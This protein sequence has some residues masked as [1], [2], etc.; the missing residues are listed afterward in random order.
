MLNGDHGYR[1]WKNL[2][3]FGFVREYPDLYAGANLLGFAGDSR[4]IC[5]ATRRPDFSNVA[6]ELG[7]PK[8]MEF[9]Q[10][11]DD[12]SGIFMTGAS[13]QEVGTGDVYVS[14]GI[15]FGIGAGNQGGAAG[16]ITDNAGLRIV[17][18]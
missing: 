7:V 16:A 14:A 3:G 15:L 10:I 12:E 1:T 17:S 9:H 4:A 13:W 5:I 2:G 18:A 8:V 11:Q 6:E